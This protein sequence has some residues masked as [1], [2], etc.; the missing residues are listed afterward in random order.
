MTGFNSCFN[1]NVQQTFSHFIF[2]TVIFPKYW[3]ILKNKLKLQFFFFINNKYIHNT[4][5]FYLYAKLKYLT[6]V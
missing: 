6:I 5:K 2:I 1:M 3:N 4:N